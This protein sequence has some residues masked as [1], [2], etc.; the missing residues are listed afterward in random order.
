LVTRF[1]YSADEETPAQ[2]QIGRPQLYICVSD[3]AAGFSYDGRAKDW[4]ATVFGA[5]HK[6]IVAPSDRAGE[7]FRV[8]RL[9][10]NFASY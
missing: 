1:P 8:T 3:Q 10:E 2:Q 4:K 9:G 6:F 7:T 5:N